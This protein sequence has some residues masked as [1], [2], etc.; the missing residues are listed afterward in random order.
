MNIKLDAEY[1]SRVERELAK[2]IG[3]HAI[4]AAE[5]AKGRSIH[6]GTIGNCSGFLLR[7]ESEKGKRVIIP[8][9]TIVNITANNKEDKKYE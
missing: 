1:L 2:E 8:I 6:T 4:V 3:N 9:A 7:L 5:T